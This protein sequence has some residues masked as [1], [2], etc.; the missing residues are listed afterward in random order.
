VDERI[1]GTTKSVTTNKPLPQFIK[2]ITS[3]PDNTHS[4]LDGI[5]WLFTILG[6]LKAFNSVANRIADVHAFISVLYMANLHA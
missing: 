5:D 6:P 4:V 3:G 1:A 2:D